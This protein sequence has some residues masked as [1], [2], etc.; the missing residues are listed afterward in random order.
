MTETFT[1][2]SKKT[3]CMALY[4]NDVISRIMIIII[5]RRLADRITEHI[6]IKQSTKLNNI[7]SNNGILIS[8]NTMLYIYIYIYI[9]TYIYVC[10]IIRD[11]VAYKDFHVLIIIIIIM[12]IF[13]CYFSGELIALIGLFI[14][15]KQI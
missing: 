5:I 13:K 6:N 7:D 10:V 3:L 15:K 9:H 8:Q 11:N 2:I 1:C 12:V 14:N 4:V